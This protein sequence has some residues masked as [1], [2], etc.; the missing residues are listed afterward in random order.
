VIV[1]GKSS[2]GGKFDFYTV[3]YDGTSGGEVT[4]GNWPL[5][6]NSGGN[7]GAIDM[8]IA[9]NND[10]VVTGYTSPPAPP[11]GGL[12]SAAIAGIV[13]GSCVGA[14]LVVYFVRRWRWGKTRQGVRGKRQNRR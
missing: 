8:A 14:G 7:D 9:D 4:T 6:Y 3:K 5:I 11:P 2:Q 13:V 1:T 12:S 10:I